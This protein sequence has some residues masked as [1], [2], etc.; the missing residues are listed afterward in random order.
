MAA[1]SA[2]VSVATIQGYAHVR[3]TPSDGIAG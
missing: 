2:E 1:I 3:P